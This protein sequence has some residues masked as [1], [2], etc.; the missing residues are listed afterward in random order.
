MK[1]RPS[2]VS[3]QEN[4]ER[5]Y[6]ILYKASRSET[7]IESTLWY[8]AAWSLIVNGYINSGSTYE[9]FCEE[10]DRIKEFYKAWWDGDLGE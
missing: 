9:E 1:K 7:K 10:M 3:D 2:K 5:A 6:K 8:G 4:V